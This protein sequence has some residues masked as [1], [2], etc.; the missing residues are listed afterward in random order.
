MTFTPPDLSEVLTN[1]Q[2]MNSRLTTCRNDL[3]AILTKEEIGYTE[4]DGVIPLIRKLPVPQLAS[5]GVNMYNKFST[6]A[7]LPAVITAKDTD[8]NEMA[9]VNVNVYRIDEGSYGDVAVTSLGTVTTGNDGT[10]TVSVPMPNDKGYFTVQARA[11]NIIGKDIGAYCTTA[12]NADDTSYSTFSIFYDTSAG[13]DVEVME[14]ENWGEGFVDVVTSS[15]AGYSGNY[16]GIKFTDLG[17]FDKTTVKD[18]RF[19]AI[20]SDR[21]NGTKTDFMAFGLA[22]NIDSWTN[23]GICAGA[24]YWYGDGTGSAGYRQ[25][26]VN[27]SYMSSQDDG[28][29]ESAGKKFY[30]TNI[31]SGYAYATV[32]DEYVDDPTV[33]Y[34]NSYTRHG[35]WSFNPDNLPSGTAYP[36]IIFNKSASSCYRSLRFYGIGVI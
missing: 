33:Q 35:A 31:E 32:A 30:D 4:G 5:L 6:G 12:L 10:A 22:F 24:K 27:I 25:E 9:N 23:L 29:P 11:G 26:Y 28:S 2:I 18:H 15:H 16:F 1:E 14:A 19:I 17:S 8:G 3:R 36:A 7:N 13:G 34:P 20:L 21:G